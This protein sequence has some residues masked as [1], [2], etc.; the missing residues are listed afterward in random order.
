MVLIDQFLLPEVRPFA[1]SATMIV[2]VGAVEL[3]SMLLGFSLS[4]MLGKA[5]DVDA[6]ADGGFAHLLSWMAV[7]GVP[8]L[9]Y[10]MIALAFFAIAG[11]LI[12]DLARAIAAPL[13]LLIAVP[14]AI[15]VALPFVR[16]TSRSMASLIPKDESYAIDIGSLVG[17]VGRV[18]VG[19]LDQG[20]PGR[21][22]VKDEYGNLH[23]VTASAAPDSPPLPQGTTVLLVDR[24][25]TRF[26]AV[27]A[28]DDLT[29]RK[30][31]A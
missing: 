11:F 19:P 18:S 21:V 28:S 6:D 27:A 20:P 8:L 13:P 16:W 10:L 24:E 12:Q 23:T 9:V 2:G 30:S 29:S 17:R 15:V 5:F 25:G 3:I 7:R 1:V 4:E 14:A 22:L 31:L 26:V